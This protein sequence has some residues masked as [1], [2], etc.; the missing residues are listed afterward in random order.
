MS[1]INGRIEI[2]SAKIGDQIGASL[3]M[4]M[5]RQCGIDPAKAIHNPMMREL[6]LK[7]GRDNDGASFMH[8][9][10]NMLILNP[11]LGVQP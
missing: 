2:N 5:M 1:R 4:N 9:C 10:R 11:A 6:T 3:V 8:C 7:Y